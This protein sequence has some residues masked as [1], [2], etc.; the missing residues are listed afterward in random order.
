[1]SEH[2]CACMSSPTSASNPS[3]S[4]RASVVSASSE[5]ARSNKYSV[6]VRWRSASLRRCNGRRQLLIREFGA[7]ERSS[8]LLTGPRGVGL[9]RDRLGGIQRRDL[10]RRVPNLAE[11]RFQRRQFP[12]VLPVD[13]LRNILERPNGFLAGIPLG[14]PSIGQV[15]QRDGRPQP[16]RGS[17][18]EDLA[19]LVDRQNGPQQPFHPQ[20]ADRKNAPVECGGKAAQPRV[21]GRPVADVDEG[22]TRQN[23]DTNSIWKMIEGRFHRRSDDLRANRRQPVAEHISSGV[24]LEQSDG[25]TAVHLGKALPQRNEGTVEIGSGGQRVRQRSK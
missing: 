9:N 5:S 4:F 11:L 13:A 1:M 6:R 21:I 10:S 14:K 12:D 3:T 18:T 20:P 7:A 2:R 22:T 17:G 16:L 24:V 19:R 25:R 23:T 15:E 8:S